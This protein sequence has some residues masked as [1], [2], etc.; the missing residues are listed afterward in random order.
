[1]RASADCQSTA[2]PSMLLAALACNCTS[3]EPFL[4]TVAVQLVSAPQP[5]DISPLAMDRTKHCE[6]LHYRAASYPVLHYA[7]PAL[8]LPALSSMFTEPAMNQLSQQ[9]HQCQAPSPHI[10]HFTT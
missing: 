4:F 3:H 10:N 7:T 5:S 9:A 8:S 6:P 2:L 1:V